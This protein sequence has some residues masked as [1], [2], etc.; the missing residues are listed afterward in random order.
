MVTLDSH[1]APVGG[2]GYVCAG[3]RRERQLACAIH[4][5]ERPTALRQAKVVA[6]G[7]IEGHSAAR[8]KADGLG[9]RRRDG[10]ATRGRKGHA[11]ACALAEQQRAA[12]CGCGDYLAAARERHV[13][14]RLARD[15]HRARC[16]NSH[17]LHA[18]LRERERLAAAHIDGRATASTDV[19]VPTVG[20]DVDCVAA[21][22]ALDVDC[23][24]PRSHANVR[25]LGG[26][27]QACL[28]LNGNASTGRRDAG[29]GSN[30]R[31]EPAGARC[32]QD[33]VAARARRRQH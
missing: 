25:L 20:S 12:R 1:G 18:R 26:E 22:I 11:V 2:H 7:G 10:N 21:L 19:D 6:A 29:I 32:E 33:G 9:R 23:A 14:A 5:N 24:V 31:R 8:G 16:T 27:R 28:S 4:G 13:C 15:G 30:R 3:G 17:A